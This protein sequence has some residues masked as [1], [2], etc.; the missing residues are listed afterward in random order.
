MKIIH[1]GDLHLDSKMESVLPKEKAKERKNEILMTFLKMIEYAIKNARPRDI[2]L[3]AGKGHETYQITATGTIHL[4][5]REVVKSVL[6][7]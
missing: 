5:E 2:I 3:L 6:E 4:D 7:G 1:C